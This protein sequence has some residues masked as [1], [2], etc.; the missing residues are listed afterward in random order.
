MF[1]ISTREKKLL[2]RNYLEDDLDVK[3]KKIEAL[4]A[5]A[6]VRERARLLPCEKS[7]FRRF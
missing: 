7:Y 1:L 2:F 4:I 5:R 6:K 3:I